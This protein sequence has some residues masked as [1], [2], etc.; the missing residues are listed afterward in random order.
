MSGT[1]ED[2]PSGRDGVGCSALSRETKLWRRAL[3]SQETQHFGG[4]AFGAVSSPHSAPSRCPEGQNPPLRKEERGRNNWHNLQSFVQPKH[5]FSGKHFL[6]YIA[7]LLMSS[8][9]NVMLRFYFL[10]WTITYFLASL[11]LA[12]NNYCLFCKL[13]PLLLPVICDLEKWFK[14][15]NANLQQQKKW[16]NIN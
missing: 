16:H 8:L 9:L 7:I 11:S 15:Q 14:W 6:I 3:S 12:A 4:A 5:G 10:I 13:Q 1:W 2:E